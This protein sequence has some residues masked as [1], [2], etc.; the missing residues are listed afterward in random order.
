MRGERHGRTS[1]G[2]RVMLVVLMVMAVAS[3]CST[4]EGQTDSE[5][6]GGVSAVPTS[7]AAP[8]SS[9]VPASP[10]APSFA[11]T[12]SD[13]SGQP[14]PDGSLAYA[15]A[16][17]VLI[18][19][20]PVVAA[21]VTLHASTAA[22]SAPVP[23]AATTTDGDGRFAFDAEIA[24]SANLYLLTS[25]GLTN[26]R[27]GDL[28]PVVVLGALLGQKRP[29]EVVINELTTV[30]GA[31]AA[32]EYF[33]GEALRGPGQAIAASAQTA[34]GLA[35][36]STGG[37]GTSALAD[38]DQLIML[39]TLGNALSSCAWN[40]PRCG[41]IVSPSGREPAA[42]TWSGMAATAR[43]PWEVGPIFAIQQ[44]YTAFAPTF[45][46]QPPPAGW[47]LLP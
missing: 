35:D 16:G 6:P 30:A 27:P 19:N 45:Q 28:P 20:E 18:Y 15:L 12:P 41:A 17:T 25:G 8:T 31:F 21:Q 46:E 42:T 29:G 40:E 10:P 39:N 4:S 7:S 47:V 26:M 36:P 37:P 3:G 34:A 24:V 13:A 14:A 43:D 2:L 38:N 9:A 5:S 33:D 22:S 11:A 1:V 32:S 23:I 44:G